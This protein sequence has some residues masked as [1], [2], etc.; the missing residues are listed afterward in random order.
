M[1]SF[2]E[3]PR[4]LNAFKKLSKGY[5]SLPED[6]ETFKKSRIAN[7]EGYI[8]D[9][10]PI[11]NLG[12]KT[13]IYKVMHFRCKSIGK[14]SRSGIRVIYAYDPEKEHITLYD[15]YYKEKDD[16]NCDREQIR[17]DFE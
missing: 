8:P 6:I 16:T 5:H 11:D 4:F 13:K 2:D 10:F 15:I 12:I 14:G 1:I 3:H 17:K 9:T 7:P